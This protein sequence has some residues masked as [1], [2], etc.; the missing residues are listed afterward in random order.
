MKKNHINKS[1][2]KNTN[3]TPD[4]KKKYEQWQ[5]IKDEPLEQQRANMAFGG[6]AST[7]NVNKTSASATSPSSEKKI[8]A[9]PLQQKTI[10]VRLCKSKRLLE[11]VR[12]RDFYSRI[13]NMVVKYHRNKI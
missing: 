13:Y 4:F 12:F 11:K 1:T 6:N 7:G 2:A 10:Q 9:R 3:F 5:K 8:T